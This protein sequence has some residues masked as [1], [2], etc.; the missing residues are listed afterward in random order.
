MR[1]IIFSFIAVGGAVF[2]DFF[3]V[4]LSAAMT[5]ALALT[6]LLA[7]ATER[8]CGRNSPLA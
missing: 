3:V 4:D 8:R 1:N 6:G 7:A 5:I 2:C